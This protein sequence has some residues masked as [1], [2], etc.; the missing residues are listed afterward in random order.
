MNITELKKYLT[1][2]LVP[3]KLY[4]IGGACNGKICLEKIG[5]LWEVFFCD[6]G[7]KFCTTSFADEQTACAGLLRELSKVMEIVYDVSL[8]PAR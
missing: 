1:D 7:S 3:A 2:H 6:K 8:T 4:Q 5:G